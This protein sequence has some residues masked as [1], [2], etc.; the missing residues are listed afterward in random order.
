MKNEITIPELL[1]DLKEEDIKVAVKRREN[2]ALVRDLQA[3]EDNEA[4][5]RRLAKD[6]EK[7][8]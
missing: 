8:G 3:K 2:Y 5:I 4:I 7:K 1:P 6:K